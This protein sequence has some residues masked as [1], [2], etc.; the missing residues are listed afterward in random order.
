MV[1]GKEVKVTFSTEQL[2]ELKRVADMQGISVSAALGQ[3]LA[4]SSFIVNAK[5]R[6]DTQ[7]LV[8]RGGDIQELE[9]AS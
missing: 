7:I 5:S 2:D 9:L 1:D 6:R 3:A 8:K 4:L